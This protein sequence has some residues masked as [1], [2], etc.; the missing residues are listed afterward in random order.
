M[1]ITF[2]FCLQTSSPSWGL[3]QGVYRSVACWSACVLASNHIKPVPKECMQQNS[4]QRDGKHATLST[5]EPPRL[6]LYIVI[7]RES[8]VLQRIL[9]PHTATRW[10]KT[11]FVSR[12]RLLKEFHKLKATVLGP[13]EAKT[14][15]APQASWLHAISCNFMYCN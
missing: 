14:Y 8:P 2:P 11:T 9:L 12:F 6:C 13:K 5:K 10:H 3:G 4:E 7:S 1:F 15:G